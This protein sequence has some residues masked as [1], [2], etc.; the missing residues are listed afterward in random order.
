[1]DLNSNYR[2]LSS[3]QLENFTPM[4]PNLYLDIWQQGLKNNNYY[5]KLCGAG[6]GGFLMGIAR[7][8]K[9]LQDNLHSQRYKTLTW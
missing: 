4:I 8:R 9:V 5:L 6:G 2:R 3:F 1:T 7:N